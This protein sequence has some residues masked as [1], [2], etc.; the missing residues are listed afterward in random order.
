MY[1]YPIQHHLFE[2]VD[3]INRPF[4]YQFNNGDSGWSSDGKKNTTTYR[5]I[6]EKAINYASFDASLNVTTL[7]NDDE[8]MGNSDNQIEK[9]IV[10]VLC[11]FIFV[12]RSLQYI[13]CIGK[14]SATRTAEA[15]N[16]R[17]SLLFSIL[18]HESRRNVVK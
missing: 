15:N 8:K 5:H 18:F 17:F 4:C 13:L 1:L 3:Y 12:R 6:A 7:T 10:Q 14:K 2:Q 11:R 16:P 9:F